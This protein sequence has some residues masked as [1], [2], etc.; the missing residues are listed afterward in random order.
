VLQAESGRRAGHRIWL[1]ANQRLFVGGTEW[2]EFAVPGDPQL[3][4]VQFVVE[5]DFEHCHVRNVHPDQAL[6]VNGIKTEARTLVNGDIVTAGTTRFSVGIQQS[7]EAE[8]LHDAIR[9]NPLRQANPDLQYRFER[10]GSGLL[11]FYGTEPSQ[12]PIEVA[13][14]LVQQHC[15]YIVAHMQ[16]SGLELPRHLTRVVDLSVRAEV[17]VTQLNPSSLVML[18]ASDEVDRFQLLEKSWGCDAI[19]GIFSTCERP[20]LLQSLL[21]STLWVYP[22]HIIR[23]QLAS[24]TGMFLHDLFKG[25]KAILVESPSPGGWELFAHSQVD[26][27]WMQLGFPNPPLAR[28]MTG[29][30]SSFS[31][32]GT[33]RSSVKSGSARP[34]AAAPSQFGAATDSA[35]PDGNVRLA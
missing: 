17:D 22:A 18:S 12:T 34:S 28:V 6:F 25:I 14:L 27:L 32:T 26:P 2:A 31:A 4:D 20:A 21:R 15:F 5:S 24:G 16:K 23:D 3:A 13:R 19:V 11:R 9:A 1:G 8:R 10:C 35:G 7:L 30:N 33:N 29:M